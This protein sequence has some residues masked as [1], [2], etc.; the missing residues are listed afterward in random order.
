ME[1]LID[2]YVSHYETHHDRMAS[3]FR[4]VHE[5]L[6][7]LR[8]LGCA[9]GVVTSKRRRSTLQ[10]LDT[11]HL[12]PFIRV[13][14]TADDVAA[15][16]PAPDPIR[17]ALRRLGGHPGRA[18]MVGDGAV[19][20]VAARAAGLLCAAALWGT[21]DIGAVLAAG[22]DYVAYTPRD[23]VALVALRNAS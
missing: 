15:A 22:P 14:V 3:L 18:L 10:A 2:A 5:M 23:V 17:E 7:G 16:K 13:A 19:D 12:N 20:I 6:A 1:N 21:R 4:G 8:R 9:M 11:F